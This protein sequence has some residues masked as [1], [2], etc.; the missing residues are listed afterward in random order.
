MVNSGSRIQRLA[1]RKIVARAVLLMGLMLA[2]L[3]SLAVHRALQENAQQRLD[4]AARSGATYIGAFLDALD[5]M[6]VVRPDAP[7]TSRLRDELAKRLGQP[8]ANEPAGSEAPGVSLSEHLPTSTLRLQLHLP[9]HWEQTYSMARLLN[10][11]SAGDSR[12]ILSLGP[13]TADLTDDVFV[14]LPGAFAEWAVHARYRGPELI[15]W[16]RHLPAASGAVIALAA[17]FAYQ[18]LKRLQN[19]YDFAVAFSQTVSEIAESNQR[20]LLD[21]IELSADWLWEVDGQH[22]FTLMSNGIRSTATMDPADFIGKRPWEL[23]FEELAEGFWDDYRQ[24][25]ASRAELRVVAPRRDPYGRLRYLEFI[26]RPMVE[27]SGHFLGYRGVGRDL[28]ARIEAAQVQ[29]ASEDRFRDL[30]ALSSDWYWEQDAAQR[31]TDIATAGGTPTPWIRERWLGHSLP[32]I[33]DEPETSGQWPELMEAQ[34]SGEAFSDFIFRIPDERPDA[35][36]YAIS[37]R[38]LRDDQGQVIGYRGVIRDITAERQVQEALAESET[39]YRTTFQQAPV[40]IASLSLDARWVEANDT[41]CQMLGFSRDELVGRAALLVTHPDDRPAERRALE[42]IASGAWPTHTREKRFTCKDGSELWVRMN[43]SLLRDQGGEARQFIAVFEDIDE[44]VA[45]LRALHASEARYRSLV[46]LSPDAIFVHH[47]GVIRLANPA[48][49]KL[50][51]AAAEGE[52]VGRQMLDLVDAE[53]QG[54]TRH[55]MEG[56]LARSANGGA[57]PEQFQFRRIDGA[58]IDVEATAVSVELDDE[59]VVLCVL[60]NIADRLAAQRALRDSEARYRDVVESVNEVI[61][62]TD[63]NGRLTFLNSAWPK[64][65]GFGIAESLGAPLS[66]FFHPDD[67]NK[68]QRRVA[69]LLSSPGSHFEAELRLRTAGGEIRWI[70]ATTRPIPATDG[71]VIGIN[72]SLDDISTRKIAEL[73]LK[74]INHELENRVQLR[75][76]ELEASNRELEAFSYSVS[77]DLRAPLR[78]IDGFAHVLEEDYRDRLDQLALQYLQRIR[79]ASH[80]MANLIDD[81]LELARLT[82][83]TLRKESVDLSDMAAQIVDDLRAECPERRTDL[84]V[85]AGLIVQADRVLIRVVMENLLRNAWKF[86]AE[87][88]TA[89]LRFFAERRD[90]VLAYCVADNG[91][92][93]DMNHAGKLFQPF[94]RLHRHSQYEGSGIGLA[95][96]QR[97]IQRHGGRVWAESAPGEGARFYFTL[98]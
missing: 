37:G 68:F 31:F 45:A 6:L 14:A 17:L 35:G 64:I 25:I 53:R 3:A 40:G 77:H 90:E 88:E 27:R 9:D 29:R 78:A 65:S 24:K 21:F 74:N 72:G 44:R 11:A 47:Q 89:K 34:R 86:S 80:R 59:K 70:E 39:R 75:T 54:D 26:G 38:P 42:C 83:Q 71:S 51:G 97:I 13:A 7:D 22:R 1:Q 94:Q 57:T 36:R 28:T 33:A 48:C 4:S 67:R 16:Q 85:T 41:L 81:L 66:E 46:D 73:T 18:I 20:R 61:F 10:E 79:A 55:R 91:T 95:T 30:V 19:R 32:Q 50:F 63:A 60:R 69:H 49:V 62:Q 84:E 58:P 56:L 52:L 76:A 92:G 87:R 43:L 2:G 82:R 15:G 5:L 98:G 96:V 8:L 12:V 23:D 93:F